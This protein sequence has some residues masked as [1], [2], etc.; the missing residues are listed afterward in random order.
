MDL[1]PEGIQPCWDYHKCWPKCLSQQTLGLTKKSEI[2]GTKKIAG[3]DFTILAIAAT[4][5]V[6]NL[7]LERFADQ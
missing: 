3:V 1:N 7:H 4:F 2:K 6:F 5:I